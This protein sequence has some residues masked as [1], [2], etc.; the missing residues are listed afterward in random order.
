ML[1]VLGGHPGEPL[2]FPLL[3]QT[4]TL[5]W[6]K[7]FNLS[8]CSSSSFGERGWSKN[9]LI[10]L[11]CFRAIFLIRCGTRHLLFQ[12]LPSQNMSIFLGTSEVNP[13]LTRACT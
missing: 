4:P 8:F 11:V 13:Y 10:C 5:I 6:D 1:N 12:G 7:S 3:P 9:C 2:K